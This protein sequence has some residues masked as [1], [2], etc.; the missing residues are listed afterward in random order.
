MAISTK[1][2]KTDITYWAWAIKDPFE[3]ESEI[4]TNHNKHTNTHMYVCMFKLHVLHIQFNLYIYICIH[5]YHMDALEKNLTP[6][7]ALKL[8][9]LEQQVVL[10]S[11][12]SKQ[13][14]KS[15]SRLK[16][17]V[18]TFPNSNKSTSF[19]SCSKAMVRQLLNKNWC[20]VGIPAVYYEGQEADNRA[21]VME[22]LGSSL[23]DLHK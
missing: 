2:A 16:R 14:K 7:V 13:M 5:T 19:T 11:P 6:D 4:T 8:C 23:L 22:H 17:S 12:A 20:L 18:R 3:S 21:M 15:Q 9:C 1:A 10:K